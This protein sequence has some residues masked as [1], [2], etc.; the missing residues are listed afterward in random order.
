MNVAKTV[1]L[2]LV[3]IISIY[4]FGVIWYRLSD[5]L[6]RTVLWQNEPEERFWVVAFG[7]RRPSCEKDLG[8]LMTIG[9]KLVKTMYF[10]LTTL[11][12]VGYGDQ[13]MVSIGE[14]FIG[15]I[16]MI[17]GVTIVSVVMS[18]FME[19]VT[20][21]SDKEDRHN[22]AKL[23]A[24]FKL[25]R[26]MRSQPNNEGTDISFE[27]KQE[28]EQ[29]FHHFWENDRVAVLLEKKHYFD[30]IPFKIQDHIMTEFLFE[31]LL[32]KT[33][34]QSF[35]RTGNEFD[36][37]FTYEIAFG[38]IPREFL[39][40]PEDRYIYEEEGDVTEIY[41][42]MKGAWCVA[43]DSFARGDLEGIEF[44]GEE[45]MKGTPDM[46]RKKI[47]IAARKRNFGLIGDYY[48]LSSKRA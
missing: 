16:F 21:L 12:T 48:V 24:W 18:D 13:S 6:I 43:F 15:C 41:F 45:N 20:S 40:T 42:I 2:A 8:D 23:Y 38:F 14:R 4:F 46:L 47:L 44:D 34:F 26:R 7:L 36:D 35:F 37:S 31:D 39:D 25:I 11:S 5:H 29:H 32:T 17:I 3:V 19:V 27:L 33:A 22:E 1:N 30:S 9:D 28:I 10:M